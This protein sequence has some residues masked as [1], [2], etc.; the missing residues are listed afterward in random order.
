MG[1]IAFTIGVFLVPFLFMGNTFSEAFYRAMTIMVVASPC[2]LVISTPA[3][4]LSAIGGAARRGILIK[5]GSHLER[6]AKVDIVAI[7]KTG[8]LTVGKPSLTEIVTPD[9]IHPVSTP[10]PEEVMALLRAAAALEAKSEHPL[11]HA[12]VQS[13]EKLGIECPSAS[14]FQSTAGKGAEATIDSI[15]YLIGS[16]R[17][18]RELNATGLDAL[19]KISQPMQS[20]GKTCVWLG[21]RDGDQVKALAVLAMADTIRPAA[22]DLV[23]QLKALGV[24]KVVM[25]TGDQ[26]LVAEAIARESHVDEVRA[27]LLPADKLEVIRKLKTEGTVM[28]V[29]DGV[30]DAPA[31]AISDL[32]VAMGAAG[33]DVAMETADIVLMGDRLEN[34]PLLLAHTRRAKRVLIQN[35]VFASAVIVFLIFAALGFSLPLPLGVIGHEGSTVLV[36]LNGL[37]LLMIGKPGN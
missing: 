4:V 37:R 25:L 30:N 10:L 31:L 17:L 13:A 23:K 35:L 1:V 19:A 15:R 21:S 8:T 28:M 22:R 9:G 34:I 3:T 2:A 33:T 7:D 29:G 26:Q 6:A 5:G 36:C 16:E 20:D 32:G 12:I 27:E 18:F 11:A 14:D 24:K